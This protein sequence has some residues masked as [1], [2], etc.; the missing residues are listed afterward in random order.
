MGRRR[1]RSHLG[2]EAEDAAS[3]PRDNG[4]E[5]SAASDGREEAS[6]LRRSGEGAAPS[7]EAA[8]ESRDGAA[9]AGVVDATTVRGGGVWTREVPPPAMGRAARAGGGRGGRR[10]AVGRSWRRLGPKYISRPFS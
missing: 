3:R 4:S 7:W 6:P 9:G 8:P 5:P 1:Q 10:G 2:G